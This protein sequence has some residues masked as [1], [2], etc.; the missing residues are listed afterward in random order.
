MTT[1]DLTDELSP[2]LSLRLKWAAAF[3]GVVFILNAVVIVTWN[4][5]QP[6]LSE[7]GA[8]L[9]TIVMVAIILTLSIAGGYMVAWESVPPT[10][11]ESSR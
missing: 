1:D 10:G 7:R 8:M 3:M 9:S 11:E 6:H 4:L 5:V 2:S